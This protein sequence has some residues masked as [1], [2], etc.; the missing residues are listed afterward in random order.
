[1][2]ITWTYTD[3]NISTTVVSTAY[4][5]DGVTL[6]DDIVDA[7]IVVAA[8]VVVVLVVDALIVVVVVID[9]PRTVADHSAGYFIQ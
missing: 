9:N 6:F 7:L 5:A 4:R 3:D 8:V 2:L 1:L